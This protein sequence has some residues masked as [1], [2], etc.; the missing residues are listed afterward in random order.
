MAEPGARASRLSSAASSPY[1][2]DPETLGELLPGEPTFRARQLVEWLYRSP[3]LVAAGMTNLP[4]SLRE[5]MEEYL[6]P[7]EVTME[8]SADAGRTR[9]WLFRAQFTFF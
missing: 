5:Q 8:Q 9:K 7:F 1:L 3:V 2:P 6:W 4:K